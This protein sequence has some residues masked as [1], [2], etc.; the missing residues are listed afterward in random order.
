VTAKG[1]VDRLARGVAAG[2]AGTTVMTATYALEH[3]I[4][5]SVQGPLDYDDG[6]VPVTAAMR[7][8]GIRELDE[9]KRRALGLLVHWGYG[10]LVGAARLAIGDRWG[11]VGG[12]AAYYGGLMVM[13]GTLFPLLGDTPPPWRWDPDV[14]ATSCVQ[15]A[16]YAVVVSAAAAE[17]APRG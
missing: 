16:V 17:L 12:T 9:G 3:R 8:L 2:F 6:T 15:H 7:V 1:W 10:S 4:R 5:R 14:L 11:P 13:A